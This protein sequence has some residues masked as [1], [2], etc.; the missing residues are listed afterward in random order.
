MGVVVS[1]NYAQWILRYPEF[2]NIPQSTATTY[3]NEATEFHRNDGGGPVC[4]STQQQTLLNMVTAHI[5]ARYAQINGIPASPIVGRIS[6]ANEGSVSV[7]TEFEVPAGTPQFW[8]QTKYGVD[9][10]VASAPFRTMRYL[11][12]PR[13]NFNAPFGGPGSGW[14]WY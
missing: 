4:S 11:P 7:Q 6:S 2:Q 13:R 3:F 14:S 10:W 12:G 9:Y 1:F 5:A 8:A